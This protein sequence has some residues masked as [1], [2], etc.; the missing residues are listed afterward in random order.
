M[1]SSSPAFAGLS[2]V[3]LH[4]D[5]FHPQAS[6][7]LTMWPALT[8]MF[9]LSLNLKKS[10][11][12]P[13]QVRLHLGALINRA[14]ALCHLHPL[15]I[16]PR[17]H[18]DM[19]VNRSSKL[20]PLSSLVIQSTLEFW[21]GDS[22]ESCPRESLSNL[23]MP[24]HILGRDASTYVWMEGDLSSFAGL[25]SMAE[26]SVFSSYQ[27]SQ[28]GDCFPNL[29]ENT[30]MVV[31]KTHPGS[32]GQHHSDTLSEQGGR[33]QVQDFGRLF[34]SVCGRGSLRLQSMFLAST[35]SRWIAC[36]PVKSI[37]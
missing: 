1:H 8:I 37:I 32:D 29:E 6:N 7:N 10:S 28:A 9:Q 22:P 20:I 5:I 25:G 12:V 4:E 26:H 36:L 13:S 24:T 17:D 33:D 35:M 23:P 11:L 21:T 2:H 31:L 18:F 30:E 14:R 27:L 16:L 34:S 3:S 19:K 15:P